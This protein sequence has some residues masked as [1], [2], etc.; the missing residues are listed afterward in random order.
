MRSVIFNTLRRNMKVSFITIVTIV[1]LISACL[2]SACVSQKPDT[3]KPALNSTTPSI[4]PS[5]TPTPESQ[6]SPS[7]FEVAKSHL[8]EYLD[9]DPK[10]NPDR[11]NIKVKSPDE[12]TIRFIQ[13]VSTDISGN[14]RMWVFGIDTDKGTELWTYNP[15]TY[16][17]SGWSII[18]L[19][20]SLSSGEII[21]EHIISPSA[22]FKKNREAIFG[23]SPTDA[24]LREIG[25]KNGIYSVTRIGTPG[26]MRFNATTGESVESNA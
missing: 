23:T 22:L 17:K 4:T 19:N 2:F 14:A 15:E 26:T 12:I 25:L 16:E 10:T 8:G 21:P 20:E 3:E 11:I 7:S 5:P 24:D 1:L 6:L 18:S 13:G 9:P